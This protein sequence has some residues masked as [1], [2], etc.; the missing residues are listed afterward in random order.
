MKTDLQITLAHLR[1]EM[2][3]CLSKMVNIN[4]QSRNVQ[5]IKEI[6]DFCLSHLVEAGF[7]QKERNDACLVAHRA[8]SMS[9]GILILGHLDTYHN[10]SRKVRELSA[11]GDILRGHGTADMKGGVAI[12]LF[13]LKYLLDIG[14][15]DQRSITVLFNA[16]EESGSESS[17]VAIEREAAQSG[18][19]LVFEPGQ[20]AD[21]EKSTF[22]IERKGLG[23]A[24]FVFPE[25]D[26]ASG[27]NA[28]GGSK[29]GA[30]FHMEFPFKDYGEVETFREDLEKMAATTHKLQERYRKMGQPAISVE[31]LRPPMIPLPRTL[32]YS[33]I[34]EKLGDETGHGM[35]VR[36]REGMSDG[37]FTAALGVPT[38]DGM[39]VVGGKWH[40][41]EEYIEIPSLVK[42]T[43]LFVR[44]WQHLEA[45]GL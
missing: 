19:V 26:S 30:T 24:Y 16:D 12:I 25:G 40:T 7:E 39:G 1:D 29:N 31:I 45:E 43:E 17:R 14:A 3:S 22:I 2:L 5:G 27:E 8:G 37:C 38:I 21:A 11:D 6:Q 36:T 44:L 28:P 23:R 4:S 34:I 32:E 33:K 20:R 35:I 42:R 15:L 13:G 18:L 9:P 41:D 10:E